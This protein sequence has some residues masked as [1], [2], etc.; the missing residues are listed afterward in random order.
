[1]LC[2]ISLNNDFLDMTQKAEATKTKIEIQNYIKLKS[3]YTTEKTNRVKR[4][5]IEWGEKCK[6]YIR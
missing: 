3:F 2:D 4:Q 5:P 6:P 1:M